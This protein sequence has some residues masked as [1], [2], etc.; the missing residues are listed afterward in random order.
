MLPPG[1]QTP[2]LALQMSSSRAA[3]VA[4]LQKASPGK[5]TTGEKKC[6]EWDE[7]WVPECLLPIFASFSTIP[8]S[9]GSINYDVLIFQ[10]AREGL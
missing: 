5:V 4:A 9:G 3:R 7:K 10:H 6:D 8:A 1:N 2:F